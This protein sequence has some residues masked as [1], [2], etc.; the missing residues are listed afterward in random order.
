MRRILFFIF[1]IYPNIVT[2]GEGEINLSFNEENAKYWQY[3]S[4]RTMGGVSNGEAT[5]EKSGEDFF[6]R[7]TGNVSTKNNGGFIQLRSKFSF[8]NFEKDNKKIKGVRLNVRGNS[9]SYY[10]FIRTTESQSYRDYYSASF[11]ANSSWEII[12]LPFNNFKHRFSNNLTLEGKNITSFG[13]VAY[14]RNF[15]SDISVSEIVFYF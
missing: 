13:I 6:V 3:I 15:T 11:I 7:L 10:I 4:D 2:A 5:L 1:I 14:G 8:A 9:E 12:D